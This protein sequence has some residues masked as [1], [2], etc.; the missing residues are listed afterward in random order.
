M[1]TIK[2]NTLL[3]A[4]GTSTTEP[5][6]PALDQR[7]ASAW[8]NFDGTGTVAIRSSYNVS[9]L[10]DIGTGDYVI[11]FTVSMPSVDFCAVGGMGSNDGET[12]SYRG[13]TGQNTVSSVRVAHKN[14]SSVYVDGSLISVAV[15]SS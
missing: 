9:S 4:D 8:V 10:S 6:I 3:A 1:S 12:L 5:S 7:M 14:L 13:G 2:V 15:L 11:N